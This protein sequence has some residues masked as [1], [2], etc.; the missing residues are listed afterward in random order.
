MSDFELSIIILIATVN[1]YIVGYRIGWAKKRVKERKLIDALDEYI[2]FIGDYVDDR[3]MFL[4]KHHRGCSQEDFEKGEELR[5][6]IEEAK[7]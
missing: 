3:E 2:K 5:K 6:K 1:S 7:K 4:K